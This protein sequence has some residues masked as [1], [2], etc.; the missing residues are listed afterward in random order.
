MKITCLGD[1]FTQGY[2]VEG[3]NYTRFL[4]KAGFSVKNLG[5]NGST[6]DQMLERYKRFKNRKE[7]ED[8]LLIFGGSNDFLSGKSIEFVYKNVKSIL[9]ISEA[10]RKIVVLPPLVEE[11]ETYY[12]YKMTNEKIKAYK[13]LYKKDQVNLIDASLIKG[14]YIDGIHLAADF[15]EKLA[16]KIIRSVDD[17]RT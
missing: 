6:T 8:I 1:S 17:R 16:E 7:K 9:K 14:R 5:V 12:L 13:N 11:E 10:R 15:H 2:L 4:E 3:R